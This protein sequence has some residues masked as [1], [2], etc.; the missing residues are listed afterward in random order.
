MKLYKNRP[1]FKNFVKR[2]FFIYLKRLY[3]KV[4]QI[5]EKIGFLKII[6]IYIYIYKIKTI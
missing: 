3:K 1:N 2:G 6:Y 5:Y 4:N